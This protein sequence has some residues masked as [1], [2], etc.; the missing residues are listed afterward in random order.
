MKSGD[1][2]ADYSEAAFAGTPVTSKSGRGLLHGLICTVANSGGIAI[3]DNTAASGNL[4]YSTASLSL[5]D[6]VT[7][8]MSIEMTKGIT[9]SLTTDG[10][11]VI[12]Y[13]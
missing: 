11:V 2:T 10:T 9:T 12:L 3:Y 1:T 13:S 6:V 5:G 8:P 4:V 7:F